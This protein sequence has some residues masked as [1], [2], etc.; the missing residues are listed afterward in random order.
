[1]PNPEISIDAEN[2]EGS[3]PYKGFDGIEVTLRLSQLVELGGKRIKRVKAAAL[4][5]D[6][7]GWDYEAARIDTF[8]DVTKVKR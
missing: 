3:G 1:M 7:A 4:E 8:T 5:K 6:I 2:F